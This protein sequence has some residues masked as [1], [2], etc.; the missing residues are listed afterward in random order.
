MTD[1]HLNMIRNNHAVFASPISLLAALS[2]SLS[3]CGFNNPSSSP[4]VIYSDT[5]NEAKQLQIPP[6][7]T[8]VS[9]AEQFIL[10]GVEVGPLA[11]NRLLPVFAGAKYVRQDNQNWL[12]FNQSAE[13]IWPLVLEFIRKEKLIVEKTEP[14]TGLIFTQWTADTEVNGGLL[15]NLISGDELFSRYTFRLERH[16]SG[17]RLFARSMQLSGDDVNNVANDQWPAMLTR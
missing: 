6:D 15:K 13:S 7:L 4:D 11:R 9:N 16:N 2:I 14:T 5:S 17:T 1:N 10:P 8:N 12:E 3:G